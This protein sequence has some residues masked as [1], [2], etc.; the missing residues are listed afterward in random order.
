MLSNTTVNGHETA[1][2]CFR[3]P[4]NTSLKLGPRLVIGHAVGSE[5]SFCMATLFVW[6]CKACGQ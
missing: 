5:T 3:V 2:D 4:A 6:L 1:G